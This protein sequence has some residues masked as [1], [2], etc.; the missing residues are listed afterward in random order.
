MIAR[1][2]GSAK[3][4]VAATWIFNGTVLFMNERYEGYKYGDIYDSLSVL[5]RL[6]F[7]EVFK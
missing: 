7:L 3:W 5:V 1:L 4:A 2:G 6:V